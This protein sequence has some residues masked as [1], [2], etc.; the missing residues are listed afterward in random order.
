MDNNDKD[1][2]LNAALTERVIGDMMRLENKQRE[3]I[4]RKLNELLYNTAD[5]CGITLY[6]LCA[7]SV[8]ELERVIKEPSR[9]D[10]GYK[11]TMET[12]IT[13]KPRR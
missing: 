8:P 6:E 3:D 13:L 2:L 4:V 9:E 5:A 10:D 11:V 12:I 7:N 1:L